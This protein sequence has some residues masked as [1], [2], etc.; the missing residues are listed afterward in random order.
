M[1][2][3]FNLRNIPVNVQFK[4]IKNVHLSVCP[5]NGH[6]RISAPNQMKIERVRIFAASKLPWI[7]RQQKKFR[8]QERETEKEF[9]DRES[10]YVWGKRYLLKIEES[11]I[12]QVTLK[13][14]Q[15][16]LK[17]KPNAD[18]KSRKEQLEVWYRKILKAEAQILIQ[19]WEKVLRVKSNQ[20]FVQKMRTKW[21]SCNPESKNIRLN[22]ELA[23]KPKEFLEYIVLHEL[24]HLIAPTHNEKF[25]ALMDRHMPK[26]AVLKSEL[27]CLPVRY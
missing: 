13:H 7:K 14:S 17:T 16:L 2:T 23:K 3:T 19:K 26:W 20:L 9:I 5:P 24:V 27:N 1:A 15:L 18:L 6:V 12:Q 4:E 10:H 25:I 22:T 11:N 8:A 21:G